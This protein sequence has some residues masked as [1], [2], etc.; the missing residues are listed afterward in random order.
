MKNEN[1]QSDAGVCP[2]CGEPNK[3]AMKIDPNA[4]ECWCDSIIIPQELLDKLPVKS[5]GKDC[6]CKNCVESFNPKA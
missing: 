6:I 5:I 2:L 3:C 1:V 4:T